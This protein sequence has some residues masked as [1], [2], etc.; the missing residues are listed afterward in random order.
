MLTAVNLSTETKIFRVIGE[1]IDCLSEK[2]FRDDCILPAGGC[3]VLV[4]RNGK[5]VGSKK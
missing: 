5:G 1:W 2:T 4:K 3:A